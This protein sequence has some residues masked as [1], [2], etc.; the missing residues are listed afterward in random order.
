MDVIFFTVILSMIILTL[1]LLVDFLLFDTAREMSDRLC[2]AVLSILFGLF[3]VFIILVIYYV[4]T[5]EV[6]PDCKYQ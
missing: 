6:R 2:G 4:V 5:G 1:L 3:I